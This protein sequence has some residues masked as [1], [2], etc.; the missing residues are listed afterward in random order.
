MWLQGGFP[1]AGG[2]RIGC[3]QHDHVV[4]EGSDKIAESERRLLTALCG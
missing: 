3:V 2:L 1:Y 4:I